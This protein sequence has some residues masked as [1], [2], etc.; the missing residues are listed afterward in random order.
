[1][2]FIPEMPVECGEYSVEIR[3]ESFYL[4][5]EDTFEAE[6]EA[7]EYPRHCIQVY[8]KKAGTVEILLE[9]IPKVIACLE[10]VA[11]HEHIEVPARV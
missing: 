5:G 3:S 7:G 6:Y 11:A 1:M 9:D 8:G 2:G 4:R 10:L